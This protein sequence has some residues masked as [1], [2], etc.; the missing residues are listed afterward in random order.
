MA[1]PVAGRIRGWLPRLVVASPVEDYA[2]IGLLA[3]VAAGLYALL[4]KHGDIWWMDAS[5]HA[6]NGAFIL[7]FL[8]QLPLR[9]PIEFAYDY[10]R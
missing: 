6:M 10:Y 7:D 3:C 9:H 2:A 1:S 8:H 5:R 4:P